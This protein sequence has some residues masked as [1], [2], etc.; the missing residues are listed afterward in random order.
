MEA[1]MK[2]KPAFLDKPGVAEYVSLSTFTIERLVQQG[3]FPQSRK[4]SDKRV[5]WLV[6]DVDEWAES[7]PLSSNLPV[8]N[9]G[10]NQ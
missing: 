4:I 6:R 7:R 2:L 8:A 1:S 9:C 3:S 10:R 5:G